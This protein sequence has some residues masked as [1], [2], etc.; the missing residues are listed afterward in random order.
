MPKRKSKLYFLR[1]GFTSVLDKS[2]TECLQCVM[3]LEIL[4]SEVLKESK[5]T[6]HLQSKHPESCKEGTE[7]FQRK[8]ANVKS[9]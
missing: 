5:L 8:E 4:S 2:G 9:N 1:F 3:C 6:R 7:F